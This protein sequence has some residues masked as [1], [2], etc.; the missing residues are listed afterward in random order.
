MNFPTWEVELALHA[1]VIHKDPLS[2]GD[3]FRVFM[4]PIVRVLQTELHCQRDDAHDSAVDAVFYYLRNPERFD[5]QKRLSTYLTQIAKRRAQDR[6]RS[7]QARIRREEKFGGEFELWRPNPKEVMERSVEARDTVRRLEQVKL[8]K[9]ENKLLEQMLLGE[10]CSRVLGE[11]L[12]LKPMP[13]REQRQE[14]K[15]H[16]D[17][18]MKKLVR[19][20]KEDSDDES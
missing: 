16:K 14:V 10:K 6:Q 20:G 19:I 11:V 13:E 3:V 4:D 18:L 1:R 2:S 17:R 15:R 5:S 8:R 9:E 7:S 12:E